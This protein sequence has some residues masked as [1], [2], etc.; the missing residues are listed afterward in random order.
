M[1]LPLDKKDAP[2]A[3][4]P[5]GSGSLRVRSEQAGHSRVPTTPSED[6]ALCF[7]QEGVTV[8]VVADG[9]GSAKEGGAAARRAVTALKQN[10]P[11]RPRS[12]TAGR[13]CEEIVRHLN[14]RLWQEGLARFVHGF[15]GKRLS[16]SGSWHNPPPDFQESF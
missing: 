11:A 15:G 1:T 6:A 5:R 13:A 8:A 12:W 4:G 16:G 2:P 7:E 10:F 9:M 14:R 3:P